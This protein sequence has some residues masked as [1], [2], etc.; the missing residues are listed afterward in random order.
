MI[1]DG[2]KL[3][4]ASFAFTGRR[5]AVDA[6]HHPGDL[7]KLLPTQA[8][9]QLVDDAD[10]DMHQTASSFQRQLAVHGTAS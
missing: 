10:A 8:L 6:A 2:Q 5:D 1:V 3:E 9:K 4:R 7:A